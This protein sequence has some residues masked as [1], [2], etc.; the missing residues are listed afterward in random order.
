[1]D[2]KYIKSNLHEWLINFVEQPN[3]KLGNWPVCPYARKA[4]LDNKFKIIFNLSTDFTESIFRSKKL[5]EEHNDVVIVCFDH[6]LISAQYIQQFVNISNQLLMKEN[7]V[8]LEDHP[9]APEYVNGICMNFGK[10]GLL[11]LQKLSNLNEA[12]NQLKAKGY[13]DYWDDQS[14]KEV[15]SWRQVSNFVE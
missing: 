6:S 1:M 4:R 8:I 15:V 12:S 5:L 14:Y 2:Q 9:D 3:N 11:L 10:C 7:I 13:Y